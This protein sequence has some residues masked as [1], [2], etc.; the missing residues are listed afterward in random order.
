MTESG[1]YGLDQMQRAWLASILDGEDYRYAVVF[2]HHALWAGSNRYVNEDYPGAD[3]LKVDWM[4][5]LLPVLGEGRVRAV[6]AGDGGVRSSGRRFDLEEIPHFIT[7]WT[8][9]RED[10]PPEW[11]SIRLDEDAVSV[12]WHRLID[13]IHY[14]RDEPEDHGSPGVPHSEMK[15]D[16]SERQGI[17]LPS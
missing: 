8:M 7:G 9:F 12:V 2:L 16:S 3:S 17:V 4:R 15:A 14:V 1:A 6:F 5:A 11:L 13:G 10:I